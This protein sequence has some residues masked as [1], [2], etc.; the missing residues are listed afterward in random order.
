VTKVDQVVG[1]SPSATINLMA[2][3]GNIKIIEANP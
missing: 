3:D 2:D 1:D